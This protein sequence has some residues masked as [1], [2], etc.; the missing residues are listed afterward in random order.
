MASGND[1]RFGLAKETTYGT[2]ATPTRFLPLT[3][4][5][6]GY[7]F[8]RYFS[9]ALGQGRWARPSVI[10]TSAGSGS[11]AGDVPST[12]FGYLLQ[13]LHGN[14]VTPVQQGATTAYLQT[15]TLDTA[16]SKS[17]TIQQQTPPVSSSTLVPLDFYGCVF[18]GITLSWAAAGVLSYEIPVMSRE[19]NTA[20]TLATYT[21]PSAW[22]LF[23]F[24]G[25]SISI[26]GSPE[27]NVVGNGSV[28]LGFSLRDD[29][30]A[31]GSSGLMAQPVETDKPTAEGTFTADFNDLSNF[32]RVTN[33]TSAD[34]LLK[35]EGAT[36]A[37]TYKY[38]LQVLIQ[39]CVFN[40]PAPT[41]TG[42]G[43]IS[44]DV[45]F[46]SASTTGDPV[47]ITYIST[48]VTV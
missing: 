26:G 16:P 25:G 46:S 21:A 4:M 40:S 45:T 22:D 47:I 31:L 9:P 32:N 48:D 2:R 30:F 13:G 10:T 44:Q 28:T 29:A 3:S 36:I 7:T 43:P 41:V 18:G 11:L 38:T 1:A 34:V 27:A 6:L 42:P 5:G 33:N 12:G 23:S 15:H 17:Y 37:S 35:F 24:K 20:Q 14:T 39:D 8:N 19:V